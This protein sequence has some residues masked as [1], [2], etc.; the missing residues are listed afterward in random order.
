MSCALT[1]MQQMHKTM[2]CTPHSLNHSIL[3]C[4]LELIAKL[5]TAEHSSWHTQR[6]IG[7]ERVGAGEK[8]SESGRVRA[9]SWTSG[10]AHCYTANGPSLEKTTHNSP[11]TWHSVNVLH[12]S[13][14]WAIKE[15]ENKIAK[16]LECVGLVCE[17]YSSR[18]RLIRKEI[19][20]PGKR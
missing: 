12:P 18:V 11:A 17:T 5:P 16:K 2:P 8:E 7:V 4:A 14:W 9:V 13:A 10:S 19:W 15:E 20:S 3:L 1:F 6:E